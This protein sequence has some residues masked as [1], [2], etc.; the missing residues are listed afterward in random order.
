[1]SG[2]KI[3]SA[4]ENVLNIFQTHI[5]DADSIMVMTFSGSVMTDLPMTRKKGNEAMI[6]SKI[7]SLVRPN[8][9]TGERSCVGSRVLHT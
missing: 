6:S 9:G 5:N 2:S 7:S 3:K 8:G 1:M 4:I